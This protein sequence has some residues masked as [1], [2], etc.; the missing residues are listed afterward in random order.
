ML[1]RR[2]R[3]RSTPLA[4]F[5]V[6]L[7]FNGLALA[8]RNAAA[9][10][11]LP[12]AIGEL[13]AG[14]ALALYLFFAALYL[15][16]L[17]VRPSALLDDIKSSPGQAGIAAATMTLMLAAAVVLPH[18]FE[19]AEALWWAGI[20]C[21]VAVIVLVAKVIRRT[22]PEG[23]LVTPFLLLPFVGLIVA[24]IAGVPLD[25]A[26]FSRV[27]TMASLLAYAVL[28]ALY[29]PRLLRARPAPPL[30]P[31]LVIFLSPAALLAIAASMLYGEIAFFAGYL[32]ATALALVLLAH[33][34]WLTNAGWNPVWGGLTFPVAAFTNMQAMAIGHDY[35]YFGIVGT[36]AGL[37]IG[38]PLIL[39]ILYRTVQ[40]FARGALAQKTGA[41]SV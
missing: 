16:K 3:W 23:R 5:P 30:R 26:E 25:H 22:P 27:L 41:V 11:L 29:V 14:A 2:E 37:L 32:A 40:A 28:I 38:T 33:A 10:L 4:V 17:S 31:T 7:G 6:L 8:W 13:L 34:R 21:H 35:G 9:T 12:P 18:S 19:L 15:R 1:S 36:L 20:A 39:Y 24:P